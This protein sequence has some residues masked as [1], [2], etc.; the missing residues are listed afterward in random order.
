MIPRAILFLAAASAWAQSWVVQTSGTT[1]SLRGVSAVNAQIAWA[2]GTNGT[3]LKTVDGGTT[4]RPM[5]P[6]GTAD[7]D[8]RDIEAIDDLT[9]YLLSSGVGLLS[10]VYKTADG[11]ESWTLIHNNPDPKGFLDCMGTWDDEHGI[12]IG[13]PL[14]GRFTVLTTNSG[15]A[16]QREKGPQAERAES[17]FASSGTCVFTRGTREA[18]FGTGGMGGARVFHSTD[19]GQT[20]SVAKVPMRHDSANAGIFSIAFANGL[21]GVAVGGDFSK[22]E[23]AAGNCAITQDG[24]K[25]WVAATAPPSGYRSAVA[26]LKEGDMW[27]ATGTSGSDV[28][29]D[30]GKTWKK[31]DGGNYNSMSFTAA[32]DGWAVGPNGAI[33]RWVKSR[34]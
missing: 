17:A 6:P 15:A 10:R 22:P 33:A 29:L 30:G 1:A 7:L 20:W 28:S 2:G 19:G 13:D 5:G 12:V 4:W 14:D 3:V 34:P 9:V 11:G 32:G 31:F 23:E 18:W 24:G 26:Y 25:T 21:H 27:I 8:F 16:L